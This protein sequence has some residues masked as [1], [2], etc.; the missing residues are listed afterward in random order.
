LFCDLLRFILT[1]N[2]V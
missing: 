2:D 1:L